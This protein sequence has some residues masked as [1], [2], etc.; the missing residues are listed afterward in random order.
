MNEE[1]IE[2]EFEKIKQELFVKRPQ[3]DKYPPDVV[4]QRR[5]LLFAQV[6]LCNIID[7]KSKKDKL[8]EE[9]ETKMYNIIMEAY[10][11]WRGK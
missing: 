1:E 5:L 11:S 2:Q 8:S 10:F 9:F 4:E 6:H 7:A 3:Y